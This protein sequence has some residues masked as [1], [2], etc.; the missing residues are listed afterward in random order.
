L[1]GDGGFGG[2]PTGA[3]KPHVI[4]KDRVPDE[5]IEVPTSLNQSLLYRL[6]GDLN[7]LHVD[8]AVARGAGFDRPILHG[9]CTFGIMGYALMRQLCGARDSDVKR[10]DVRFSR[11]VIPGETLRIDIW[12]ES[13]GR[14]AVRATV[15]ARDTIVIDNGLFEYQVR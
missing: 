13:P 12:R 11:P 5:S 3:P 1:R 14:A 6:S 15:P 7:P 4:P 9:L 2:K 10:F 8:P